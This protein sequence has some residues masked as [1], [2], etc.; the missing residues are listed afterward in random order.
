MDRTGARANPSGSRWVEMPASAIRATS[1]GRAVER[2][3]WPVLEE[4]S[5]Y[6][7]CVHNAIHDNRDRHNA[8]AFLDHIIGL[9]ADPGLLE[10]GHPTGVHSLGS[11]CFRV[12]A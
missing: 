1:T 4:N 5:R 2:R 9:F 3:L 6:G 10:F 7:P 8:L 12:F 11:P